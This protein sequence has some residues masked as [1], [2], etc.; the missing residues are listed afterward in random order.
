MHI[1]RR[2]VLG[3]AIIVTAVS[4]A[5][6]CERVDNPN[7]PLMQA[8]PSFKDRAP[9]FVANNSPFVKEIEARIRANAGRGLTAQEVALTKDQRA[10]WKWVGALH[11]RA[12]QEGI[13]DQSI[14]G[15]SSAAARCAARARYGMKYAAT[16]G[17]PLTDA[18][19]AAVV[20]TVNEQFDSCLTVPSGRI[21]SLHTATNLSTED[22]IRVDTLSAR[23]IDYTYALGNQLGN[24]SSLQDANNIVNS[25][26]VTVNND[27][28]LSPVLR[29]ALSAA[30]SIAASSA[31]EWDSYYV[32][33]GTS[34]PHE[35]EMNMFIWGWLSAA[36]KYVSQIVRGDVYGCG[37]GMIGL[38]VM[39]ADT[40][41][42]LTLPEFGQG[43]VYA[44]G[45]GAITGSIMAAF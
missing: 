1:S 41:L 10:K 3:L 28:S 34:D 33:D 32:G 8:I 42:A 17:S 18:N 30:A 9:A 35:W 23:F 36:G 37:Y 25:F 22:Q 4:I 6:A 24:A 44:C 15:L 7:A 14:K 13:R 29:D 43:L 11:H 16:G 45:G 27:P 39:M 26:L 31:A 19:R 2:S 12:M 21:F 5:I 20:R 38:M 40:H